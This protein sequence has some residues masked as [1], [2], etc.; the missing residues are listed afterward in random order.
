MRENHHLPMRTRLLAAAVLILAGAGCGAP[1]PAAPASQAVNA[2]PAA[3]GSDAVSIVGFAFEPA[4]ITV[5]TGETVTWTNQASA[6]HTVVADDG[7][8]QSGDL[9]T[10]ATFTHTFDAP[11][12][13]AYRCGI[14]PSMHG[15]VVVE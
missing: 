15:T 5:K 1:A 4:T 8:F 9:A 12:T 6:D 11:G 3:V 14:H 7:S 13:Y 10:G 2:A